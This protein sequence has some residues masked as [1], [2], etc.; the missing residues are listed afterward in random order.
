MGK[1]VLLV[2]DEPRILSAL[3]RVL[4]PLEISIEATDDPRRAVE[5][6]EASPPRVLVTDYHMPWMDGV[7][8]LREARR[9]AP[10]TVRILL[11]AGAASQQIVEAINV[12]RIFRFVAKPWDDDAF[13]ALVLEAVEA[14][15][16]GRRRVSAE[17][18]RHS[19]RMML[20]RVR[21]L[22]LGLYPKPRVVLGSGEAACACAPCEHATGDYVDV[23][24]LDRDRTALIVGDVAGHGL[25]AALFAV[26]ARALVRW[27]LAEGDDVATV[28]ARANRLLCH[29]LGGGRF[30]TLFTAV[31]DAAAGHLEYVN[32]GHLPA[33]LTGPEG[34]R[35][36]ER[37][38]LPL[39]LMEDARHGVR[40]VPC[41]PADLLLA[42]TDGL[43]EARDAH[44]EF[45]GVERV[46]AA[47]AV[48]PVSPPEQLRA[49]T[50]ALLA[51]A[52]ADAAQDD[53]TLLA[54]RP[55]AR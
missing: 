4:D 5:I 52:G 41:G 30:L 13:A 43:T 24:A 26:E 32:A 35:E 47:L 42:Y 12:G 27:G 22:Q 15:D 20:R 33:L 2:D 14:H 16:L 29:D 18:E 23:V 7:A 8:V 49:L 21:K 48:G 11:T 51:F 28:V 9:L 19:L 54:Y 17:E 31:H 55:R 45:F 46:K 6:L 39:G 50:D 25:E 38:G 37:T 53:L 1:D 36:L 40:R 44:D 34:V 10:D 3:R